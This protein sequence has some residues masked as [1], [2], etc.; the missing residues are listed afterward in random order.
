MFVVFWRAAILAEI[1]G[2]FDGLIASKL[3]SHRFQCVGEK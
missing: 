2:G 1:F 3:G